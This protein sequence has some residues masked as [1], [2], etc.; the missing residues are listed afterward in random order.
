MALCD[1]S[2]SE[3]EPDGKRAI[4]LPGSKHFDLGER[5]ARPQVAVYALAFCPT[6]KIQSCFRE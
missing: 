3:T 1:T 2:D 6:G 4:R 5:R